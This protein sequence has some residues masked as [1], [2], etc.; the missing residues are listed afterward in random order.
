MD[1]FD[2]FPS[3]RSL[4]I[5]ASVEE[6]GEDCF[7][8]STC[9]DHVTFEPGSQLRILRRGAFLGSTIHSIHIPPGVTALCERC[10]DSCESLSIVTCLPGS[11]LTEIGR[12]AFGAG[13]ASAIEARNNA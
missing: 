8:C 1:W 4:C 2:R 7:R 12:W 3:E 11:Q 5:P 13:L 10:L 9:V 6:I